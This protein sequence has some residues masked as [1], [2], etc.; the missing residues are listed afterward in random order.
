MDFVALKAEIDNDPQTLGYKTGGPG[1]YKDDMTIAAIL[2]TV[3]DTT[4]INRDIIKTWE[5]LV[6]TDQTEYNSLTS[7]QKTMYQLLL[8]TGEVDA[9]SASLRTFVTNLFPVGSTTR[10]NLGN[11]I[12]RKASRA[13]ELLGLGVTVTSLDVAK[14]L[15]G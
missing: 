11:M 4:K 8:S 2:N 13:E 7:G 5:I 3:R 14:A 6:N 15:R 1:T 12:Q 10:T 9:Q